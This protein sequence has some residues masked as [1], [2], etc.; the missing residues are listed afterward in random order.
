MIEDIKKELKV[1]DVFNF[2]EEP[3]IYWWLDE[4]GGRKEA[5]IRL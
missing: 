1:F 4:N 3:H 5:K 2:E